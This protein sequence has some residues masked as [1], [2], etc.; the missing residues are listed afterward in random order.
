MTNE[1]LK[2]DIIFKHMKAMHKELKENG[3]S[4]MLIM[5]CDDA[6][7]REIGQNISIYQYN[8]QD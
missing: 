8:N 4:T 2:K 5:K 3:I 1:Q 6:N 7:L